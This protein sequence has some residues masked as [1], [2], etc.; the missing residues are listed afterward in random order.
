MKAY[1]ILDGGGVLGAALVGCL[2]AAEQMN[3]ECVGYAGTS[4]GSIVALLASVGYTPDEMFEVMC[5]EIDFVEFLD[6]GGRL[7]ES[8]SNLMNRPG[9]WGLLTRW[10]TLRRIHRELGLYHGRELKNFLT[11]KIRSKV[12]H[13]D[14]HSI[15]FEALDRAGC[16][17]LKI[18]A[19]DVGLQR[20]IVFASQKSDG[21]NEQVV[22]AVRASISY[23]MVFQPVRVHDRYLV[24]GGLCSNLPVFAFERERRETNLPIVAFD[25]VY[26]ARPIE[27]SYGLLQFCRDM[28]STSLESHDLL[29]RDRISGIHYIPVPVPDGLDALKFSLPPSER[30]MLFHRGYN[31]AMEYFTSKVFHWSQTS[32]EAERLQALMDVEP[33]RVRELLEAIARDVGSLSHARGLRCAVMLPT[34]R[35][36][37]IVVYHFNMDRDPDIDLEI[38]TTAGCTGAS[39]KER[40]PA[41][42][43]LDDARSAPEKWGLTRAQQNKVP[44]KQKS[45]VSVP[46]FDLRRGLLSGT[47]ILELDLLGT[48]SLDSTTTLADT[49]WLT[50]E[51]ADPEFIDKLKFWAD[52]VAKFLT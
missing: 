36:T 42:G 24:D 8:F 49:G 38:P 33:D 13:L 39:W 20:P 27:P 4:A 25:L 1:A 14:N 16:K 30:E 52:V 32:N 12:R 23:P 19:S 26:S 44:I 10:R 22:D 40:G 31:A 45:S 29:M 46:I 21:H 6:D 41:F 5:R 37:R 50:P 17:P 47:G 11:R 2:K 7:L 43:N 35:D 9:L 3:I 51:G 15:D 28:I 48:L 18:I 34:G